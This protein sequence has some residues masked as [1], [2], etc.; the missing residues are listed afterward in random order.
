[1][2]AGVLTG[3]IGDQDD[4]EAATE[5]LQTIEDNYFEAV[6]PRK[7]EDASV[8]GMVRELRDRYDDRFS[9]YFTAEQL[10]D[11][12]AATSGEFDGVGLTVNEVAKGLRVADVFADTPAEG[13][14]IKQG[15]LIVSVD[16]KSIAGVPSEVSTARIKGP[17]G[18]EV[19]LGVVPA[20]GGGKRELQVE[21]AEVRVPAVDG[22]I[23]T[24]DGR[25]IAYVR[26]A[27]FSQG[28]ARRAARHD[29]ASRPRGRRGP[30]PRPARQRR[31]A[32]QRGGAVREHLRRRGH[33]RLD[34]E[35]HPGGAPPTRRSATRSSRARPWS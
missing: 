2:L 29:R 17:P 21:R 5:A 4:P 20:N 30:G 6:E 19:E 22:E 3:A 10:K 16:G 12:N 27:T 1:M 7:L 23:R 9:H 31:R 18:T 14:G 26:F 24:V 34:Q 15:D 35:P 33:G 32:A 25:D 11:F 28:V 8:N 13:A